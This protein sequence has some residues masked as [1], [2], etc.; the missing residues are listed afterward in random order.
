MNCQSCGLPMMIDADHGGGRIDNPNCRYC[1][2][3]SGNLK[4]KEEIREGMINLYMQS[5]GKPREE[6]EKE[7]DAR[8]SEMPAWAAAV[9]PVEPV[10]A[11]IPEPVSV[12]EPVPTTVPVSA[13]VSAPYPEPIISETPVAETNSV[14][15]VPVS[16]P[17]SDTPPTAPV[18]PVIP[19]QDPN[20]D[21]NPGY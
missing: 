4:S 6:A 20:K 3:E 18:N 21:Q 2:D 17:I 16:Q 8:M 13:P 11:V 14:P 12:S 19:P 1:T 9:N 15:V 7:V 10:P 5:F